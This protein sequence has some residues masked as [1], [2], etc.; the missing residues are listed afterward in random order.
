MKS[1]NYNE[2]L[3]E[4]ASLL[5]PYQGQGSLVYNQKTMPNY[6]D[7][8]TA[9][10]SNANLPFLVG[11]GVTEAVDAF[12]RTLA[13]AL[14]VTGLADWLVDCCVCRRPLVLWKQDSEMNCQSICLSHIC[15]T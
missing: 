8:N 2:H 4:Y 7:T 3:A 6:D 1:T 9:V 5:S 11:S 13:T 10:K 12:C 15:F 14:V